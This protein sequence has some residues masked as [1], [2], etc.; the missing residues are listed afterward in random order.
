MATGPRY[1]V[2]FRRKR[3]GKTDYRKRLKL[4]LSE[5]PRFVVR[6]TS[7]RFLAQLTE[8]QPQGDIVLACSDSKELANYGW[9]GGGSNLP[10]AY[11]VGLLCGQKALEKKIKQGVL[12]LGLATPIA[13][14]GIFAVLKGAL[15]AGLE[16]AHQDTTIPNEGRIRGEHIASYGTVL[17]GDKKKRFS[18]YLGKGLDPEHLPKHF[19]EVKKRIIAGKQGVVG[20][21]KS[22]P[23]KGKE[24]NP[25]PTKSGMKNLN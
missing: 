24:K 7:K 13:G 23:H 11:L 2:T 1:R 16:I 4:L 6:K 17:A 14:G 22:K 10:A 8:Y 12:D 15:D 3:E 21:G 9:K 5:R 18:K 20:V 19:E 25:R